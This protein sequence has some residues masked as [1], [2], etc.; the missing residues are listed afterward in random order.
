M[1]FSS[2]MPGRLQLRGAA[3]CVAC[4][5]GNG[6]DVRLASSAGVPDA[7]LCGLK[8]PR[9][10]P[11]SLVMWTCL[12]HLRRLHTLGNT[13]LSTR[14]LG[15]V[16]VPPHAHN[17]ALWV[18]DL[19][20]ANT[21]SIRA[22]QVEI[23]A[24][25]QSLV[26]SFP[27]VDIPLDLSGAMVTAVLLG[28]AECVLLGTAS[29]ISAVAI[30]V[31]IN[32]TVSH[33]MQADDDEAAPL[34]ST[35]TSVRRTWWQSNDTVRNASESGLFATPPL[36]WNGEYF[37]LKSLHAAATPSPVR[38]DSDTRCSCHSLG[39]LPLRCFRATSRRTRGRKIHVSH[40]IHGTRISY[41]GRAYYYST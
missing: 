25:G 3:G 16:R 31:T 26:A 11:G 19:W 22:S 18:A 39:C 15:K 30:A 41:V 21:T 34:P 5:A 13:A 35:S 33:T 24:A 36:G 29:N 10:Y 2:V 28:G 1:R 20:A 37:P 17:P 14:M 6:L 4:C 9:Q 8:Q 32:T 7:G 40:T 38:H 23:D 12:L 27:T